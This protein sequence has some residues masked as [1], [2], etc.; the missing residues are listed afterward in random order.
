[1][2]ATCSH[3]W[4]IGAIRLGASAFLCAVQ[5]NTVSAQIVYPAPPLVIQDQVWATG[6]HHYGQSP[7][8]VSPNDPGLPME[9]SGTADAEFVSGTEVHLTDGF[10]A[11]SFTSD[12][13]FRARIGEPFGDQASMVLIP[14]EPGAQIV[15]GVVH[16]PKW[17]KLEI[18]I[19]LPQAYRDAIDS[20][21][22]HYYYNGYNAPTT[23]G[24]I[25]EVHDLNPYADDS[26]QLVMRLM[27]PNGQ[28]TLKWGFFMREAQWENETSDLALLV[29]DTD[30]PLSPYTIRFRY[31]PDMEGDW[32]M[33][34]SLKA[35]FTQNAH[36]DPL[37]E[38]VYNALSFTCTT[39]LP[40]NKGNLHVNDEN[41]RVL[42]FDTGE[43]FFAMGPNLADQDG[44]PTEAQ[45]DQAG[46]PG[47][48]WF[49][50][51]HDILMETMEQLHDVGGNFARMWLTKYIFQPE[52][53]NL[54]VYDSYY[55]NRCDN[56]SIRKGNCQFQCYAFDMVLEQ[57]RAKN[58]YIQL[59]VD[60]Q[61]YPGL[62]NQKEDWG[63]NPIW[64]NFIQPFPGAAGNP[65]DMKR[66][67][68]SPDVNGQPSRDQ[69]SFYYWKRKL[70]YMM[71][72]WGYSVNLPII[73]PF[74]E[75]DQL[76]SYRTVAV[77]GNCG[78]NNGLWQVDPDLSSTMDSW[79]TDLTTFIRGE[80]N[81]TDPINSSLGEE[82]LFTMSYAWSGA[83]RSDRD[84]FYRP[85]N[86]PNVDFMDVHWY[87]FPNAS[88]IGQ[89]D[90]FS[91]YMN[92]GPRDYF[93][94]FPTNGGAKKPFNQGE[95]S[96]ATELPGWNGQIEGIFYNYDVSFHN[97]IWAGAFSGAMGTGATWKWGRVFWWQNAYTLRVPNGDATDPEY[98]FN[99]PAGFSNVL[100]ETNVLN[101][102]GTSV[103]VKNRRIHHH[104]RPLADLLA[105]P[106]WQPYNF[107][108][109]AFTPERF[110]DEDISDG[111]NEL[112]AYY[113]RDGQPEDQSTVAIGWVHNRNAWTL[114]GHYLF[115]TEENFLG[116]DVPDPTTSSSITLHGFAPTEEYNVTWFPTRVNSTT[117]PDAM[118]LTSSATGLLTIDLTG[119]FG[120][121][122][123]NY[124]DTLRSDFAFIITQEPFFKSR[125][126][127]SSA[128]DP[129][130]YSNWD[131]IAYPNPTRDVLFITLPEDIT[132]DIDLLEPSGRCVIDLNKLSGSIHRIPIVGLAK[133]VYFIVVS[134][135]EQRKAKKLI[136]H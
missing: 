95:Q 87:A 72:R 31:A 58:I 130:A 120:G 26:L 36:G 85:F 37:S 25:D 48:L 114:N 79:I 99:N 59:T 3:F 11:G 78:P 4:R 112:E 88:H 133:G 57:A 39:P 33:E 18:G 7:I 6:T 52:F 81:E 64:L 53:K 110:F 34:L 80:V 92:D 55:S 43:P 69:G 16:V 40:D 97:Q 122:N 50:L 17:E 30:G 67:F 65:R 73:E 41:R 134:Q 22:N 15:D 23:S 84:A 76:L 98:T 46:L 108:S 32:T 49:K 51:R 54:G 66:Y 107:L 119:E 105:H 45:V 61:S 101:I 109:N 1:M 123:G 8:I 89:P 21:F 14:S 136:I 12:G 24:N 35:P 19:E 44:G 68:Y 115:H 77:S 106:S 117:H 86:N 121:V 124:M 96:Y 20:F 10:H 91:D 94:E 42:Q 132:V 29:A 83:F 71:S 63:H 56:E 128:S 126:I 62:G 131:F 116:C 103:G 27:K 38:V 104:F 82:K 102:D 90:G 129:G 5:G 28:E 113:L 75:T 2:R 135:G 9:L 118:E 70:K 125:P 60:A 111:L 127:L 100:G 93:N 74:N 13:R 47:D